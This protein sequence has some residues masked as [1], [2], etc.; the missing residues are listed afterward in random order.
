[1]EKTITLA[2][3]A[4]EADVSYG[5]ASQAMRGVGEVAAA[6]AARVREVATRLGYQPNAAGALLAASRHGRAGRRKP[7][8]LAIQA[9]N[10]TSGDRAFA[11]ACAKLG[12]NAKTL[13]PAPGTD[14]AAW[15]RQLWQQGAEGLLIL[16]SL[17]E[18]R[19]DWS[20]IDL[21]RFALV[22]RGRIL[23]DLPIHCVRMS[24]SLAVDLALRHIVD[25]GYKRI[26]AVFLETPSQLDDDVRRGITL[27]YREKVRRQ[28]VHIRVPNFHV[29]VWEHDQEAFLE[30]LDRE[31]A[32]FR[33]DAVLAFP[34]ALLRG[35]RER[36]HR[37]PEDF[38]F[39]S[40]AMVTGTER[41]DISGCP[42]QADEQIRR[43][44]YR[45]HQTLL[46][47]DRGIPVQV[48]EH[49]MTPVWHPGNTLPSRVRSK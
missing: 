44:A 33:P 45:L 5:T 37:V 31:I 21:S 28:K 19:P 26:L 42:A 16:S 17:D 8:L 38:G 2:D 29:P 15:F 12:Y 41:D 34:R 3:V 49:T 23:P 46:A 1:M 35:L 36:G 25:L 48:N 30:Q 24:S 14:L 10:A 32:D 20:K 13:R 39:A 18:F 4:R 9:P 47:N 6:T 22:K 43:A 11:E 27:N 40:T 7:L